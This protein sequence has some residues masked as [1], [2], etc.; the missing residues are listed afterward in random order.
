M[1]DPSSI[2]KA[3]KITVDIIVYVKKV[4][5]APKER[6]TLLKEL[7]DARYLLESLKHR[8]EKPHCNN[9]STQTMKWLATRGGPLEQYEQALETL[10]SN[11][12]SGDGIKKVGKN[13]MWPFDQ[14]EINDVLG[15][16]E[17]QKSL[18]QLALQND[19]E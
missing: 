6:E 18:F 4:A 12:K 3:I 15:R 9:E 8:A 11:V 7:E 17:R 1:V 10:S 19:L 16:I 13:L 14:K 5:N 2:V